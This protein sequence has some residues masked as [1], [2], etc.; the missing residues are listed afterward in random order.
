MR[1]REPD[2]RPRDPRGDDDSTAPPFS[3]RTVA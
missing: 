1:Q 2:H 3:D